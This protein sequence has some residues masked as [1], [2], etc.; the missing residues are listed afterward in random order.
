MSMIIVKQ[1]ANATL[2]I[3]NDA[4]ALEY[5]RIV[6]RRPKDEWQQNQQTQEFYL[7]LSKDRD[8]K[9]LRNQAPQLPFKLP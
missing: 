2:L 4:Q 8:R 1:T 5:R 7:R 3:A 9:I 6:M